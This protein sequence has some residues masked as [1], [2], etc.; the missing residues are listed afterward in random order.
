MP[1]LTIYLDKKSGQIIE[2]AA[3]RASQSVSRWARDK[4][5]LAAGA[6][7]WPDGYPD[8]LGQLNDP[9]FH[10]PP[11]LPAELDAPANFSSI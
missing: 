7:D 9:T 11:E 4:L 5:V 1:Q 8:L 10:A 3:H 2:L 6:P